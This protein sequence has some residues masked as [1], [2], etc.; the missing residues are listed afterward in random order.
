MLVSGRVAITYNNPNWWNAGLKFFFSRLY[1]K[2]VFVCFSLFVC[3]ICTYRH[4][5]AF[6]HKDRVHRS[7]ETAL[8]FYVLQNSLLEA[9]KRE[10]RTS[11][12]TPPWRAVVIQDELVVGFTPE[13]L[14]RVGSPGFSQNKN[15]ETVPSVPLCTLKWAFTLWFFRCGSHYFGYLPCDFSHPP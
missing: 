11:E 6:F 5:T 9:E 13:W 4:E 8:K 3:T 2:K 10:R 14:C 7:L 12:N 1:P 15:W